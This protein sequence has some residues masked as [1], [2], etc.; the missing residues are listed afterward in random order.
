MVNQEQTEIAMVIHQ[1]AL[2]MEGK[3]E[4]KRRGCDEYLSTAQR[5]YGTIT[6]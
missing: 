4:E 1:L 2:S 5:T 3:E 6:Q